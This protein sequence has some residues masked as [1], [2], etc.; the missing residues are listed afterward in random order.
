[1]FLLIFVLL[2][3]FS[4]MCAKISDI[5]CLIYWQI[6]MYTRAIFDFGYAGLTLFDCSFVAIISVRKTLGWHFYLI[7][8]SLVHLDWNRFDYSTLIN[9]RF[10]VS[11]VKPKRRLFQN[12]HESSTFLNKEL[13]NVMKCLNA[14]RLSLNIDKIYFMIFRPNE[15]MKSLLQF[16]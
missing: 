4:A 8:E 11:C 14:N 5:T 9:G 16:I 15:K 3:I 2:F 7:G 6:K 12:L 13:S 1:M 10:I